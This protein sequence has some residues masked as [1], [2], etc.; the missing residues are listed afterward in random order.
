[1]IT[2]AKTQHRCQEM[3]PGDPASLIKFQQPSA[4]RLT[5]RVGNRK[6]RPKVAKTHEQRSPATHRPNNSAASRNKCCT[7]QRKSGRPSTN[8]ISQPARPTQI[9][10]QIP[11]NETFH[12]NPKYQIQEIHEDGTPATN[13]KLPLPEQAS[14]P[15][16]QPSLS[17]GPPKFATLRILWSLHPFPTH[18]SVHSL[19][20]VLL[21]TEPIR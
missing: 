20:Q 14:S 3:G 5:G 11:S 2:K 21:H 17:S 19:L 8:Q 4:N 9:L 15:S 12:G 13:L 16:D 6:D 10:R 18:A 1:M 7:D